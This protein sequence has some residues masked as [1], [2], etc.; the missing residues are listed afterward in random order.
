MSGPHGVQS[1]CEQDMMSRARP[2]R[3]LFQIRSREGPADVC[4][5]LTAI[6]P[7]LDSAQGTSDEEPIGLVLTSSQ[8]P[9]VI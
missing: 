1:A 8:F 9:S 3:A 5:H 6:G 4:A 7:A 2:P